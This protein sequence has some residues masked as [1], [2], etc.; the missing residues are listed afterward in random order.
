MANSLARLRD[1]AET[2]TLH[3]WNAHL[4]SD[5]PAQLQELQGFRDP[6]RHIRFRSIEVK[7]VF[8][9]FDGSPDGDLV[10][11][12]A[13]SLIER[14]QV[15]LSSDG[16]PMQ[17]LDFALK[18]GR[19]SSRH[20][21]LRAVLDFFSVPDED[22][23]YN[24]IGLERE[25]GL[26][27]ERFED[28]HFVCLYS[29][30]QR[31]APDSNSSM[32]SSAIL[33]CLS[34][35]YDYFKLKS[36]LWRCTPLTY[37]MDRSRSSVDKIA[38]IHLHPKCFCPWEERN[39]NE[40]R[41]PWQECIVQAGIRKKVRYRSRPTVSLFFDLRK[42]TLAMEQLADDHL[43]RFSKF[44][45]TI[46][47]DAKGI[48]FRHG[49]FF[50]KETG[51]GLSCH[52]VPFNLESSAI[53]SESPEARAYQASVELV[54]R[55]SE[56][57]GE[58]QKHLIFGVGGLGAAVGLHAGQA[59]WLCEKGQVCAIGDSVVLAARLCA[60]AEVNSIFV[61]NSFF[62]AILG[63][64]DAATITRFSRK[65]YSGKEFDKGGGLFGYSIRVLG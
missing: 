52:F 45:S 4:Q 5:K 64:L 41:W 13:K 62:Q 8:G 60:E 38:A 56:L 3:T 14:K 6:L 25:D 55:V 16:P 35:H 20:P 26:Y 57:C 7:A 28:L 51:D 29:K 27:W 23:A 21:T 59:V 42:S 22:D 11:F 33:E 49:G 12:W 30:T 63:E 36:P 44:I 61:S 34:F 32:S 40:F 39:N 31:A 46:V 2:A 1:G 18:L 37:L 50:D 19:L 65:E 48:V 43:G 47:N 58:F 15:V 24:A 53:D 54:R 9:F 10:Y 17:L